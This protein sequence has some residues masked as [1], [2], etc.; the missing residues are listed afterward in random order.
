[1]PRAAVKRE[2]KGSGSENFFPQRL[3]EKLRLNTVSHR[4][5]QSLLFFHFQLEILSEWIRYSRSILFP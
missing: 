2:E 5:L 3:Q 1:M 4:S